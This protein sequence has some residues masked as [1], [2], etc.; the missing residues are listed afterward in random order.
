[1]PL[2]EEGQVGERIDLLLDLDLYIIIART[3]VGNRCCIICITCITCV[4]IAGAAWRFSNSFFNSSSV[5]VLRSW[6]IRKKEFPP[7]KYITSASSKTD[8]VGAVA[9]F[10]SAGKRIRKKDL[11]AIAM[12]YGYVYVAQVSIGASQMQLFNVL[13]EAEAYP[14]PSLVIAY[15]PC[16]NHG[17]KGGMTR[18]QTV[19]KEAVACGYWHLWHYNPQLEEQ[20][21]NPFVMDS[22]EPD[23]SKFRDFLMKEVRYTSLKKSFPA[24]AEELFAAAEENAKWRYNSYQRLAKMEY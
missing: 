23:W 10:A 20:G 1:M 18:T 13:K 14:G 22:K 16:I 4:R 8:P 3:C 6:S 2:G 21:K 17:I 5:P 11:G 19:G 12:T 15:A 24:E 7:V 9:K